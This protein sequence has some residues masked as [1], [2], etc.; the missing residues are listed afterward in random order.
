VHG[1]PKRDTPPLGGMAFM[2]CVLCEPQPAHGSGA[3]YI[4]VQVPVVC[5]VMPATVALSC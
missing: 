3:V 4:G 1:V 2:I 5:P